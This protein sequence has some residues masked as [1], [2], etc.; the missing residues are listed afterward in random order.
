MGSGDLKT[1]CPSGDA[2]P[3]RRRSDALCG[4]LGIE[5]NWP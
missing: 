1:A 3:T 5:N 4:H 2:D